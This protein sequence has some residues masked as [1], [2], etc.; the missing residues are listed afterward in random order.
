MELR[1][2]LFP[3]GLAIIWV[4]IAAMAMVDFAKF[5]AST[6][7]VPAAI[8]HAQPAQRPQARSANLARD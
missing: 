7:V 2:L 1:K 8:V 4:L 6:Q 3:I 5:N